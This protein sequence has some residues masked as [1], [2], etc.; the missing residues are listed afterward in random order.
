[1]ETKISLMVT[2]LLARTFFIAACNKEESTIASSAHAT[3]SDIVVSASDS[4][5]GKDSVYFRHECGAGETR[6][7][8][9]ESDLPAAIGI[10]LETNYAGYTFAKAF[11][12]TDTTGTVT[13]Y[14][15]VIY[16]NDE[17]VA[18]EFDSNGDF[19]GVL[20]RR[21]FGDHHRGRHD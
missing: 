2:G 8:I 1:M 14:V 12:V 3:E 17:P 13:G 9:A 20:E 18:I 16:F 19:V 4:G 21:G 5:V 10:Y 11:S 7:S 6:D 15:A